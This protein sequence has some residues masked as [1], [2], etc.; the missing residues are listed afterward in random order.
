[1]ARIVQEPEATPDS[2][3]DR[4]SR[5]G[6]ADVFIIV[7]VLI[8]VPGGLRDTTRRSPY[9]RIPLENRKIQPR[10]GPGRGFAV[11]GSASGLDFPVF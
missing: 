9:C 7:P 8:I 1:M 2:D 10:R 3:P 11:A 5:S 4:G 6:T